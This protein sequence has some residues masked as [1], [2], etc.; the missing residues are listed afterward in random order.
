MYK[1]AYISNV[2]ISHLDVFVSIVCLKAFLNKC[3]GDDTKAAVRQGLNCSKNKNINK[4]W[5]KTIFNMADGIL[6]PFVR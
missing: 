1:N 4:I 5:R 6:T 2:T 3:I